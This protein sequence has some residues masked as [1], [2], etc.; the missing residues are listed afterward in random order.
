M[1]S[2]TR[3]YSYI[4]MYMSDLRSRT[5][6]V[7]SRYAIWLRFTG[8]LWGKLPSHERHGVNINHLSGYRVYH[9]VPKM[10]KNIDDNHPGQH[11]STILHLI[12]VRAFETNDK[13]FH[14]LRY[15]VTTHFGSNQQALQKQD[16]SPWPSVEYS[17]AP[18]KLRHFLLNSRYKYPIARP[19]A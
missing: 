4:I 12:S 9:S 3:A 6:F 7:Y 16:R 18:L 10:L 1:T 17:A 14:D 8:S 19:R 13:R 5:T 15:R 11:Y 2:H